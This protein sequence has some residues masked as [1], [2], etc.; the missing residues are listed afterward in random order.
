LYNLLVV[1]IFQGVDIGTFTVI[2]MM[3]V[4]TA[5]DLLEIATLKLG[6]PKANTLKSLAKWYGKKQLDGKIQYVSHG[7]NLGCT[8][9]QTGFT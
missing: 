2:S 1:S 4:V 3:P 6:P 9:Q 8:T 7:R 5:S